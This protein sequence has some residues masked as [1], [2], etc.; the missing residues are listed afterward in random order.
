LATFVCAQEPPL[1]LSVV[2]GLPS[3]QLPDE[4][5][6]TPAWQVPLPQTLGEVQVVPFGAV[7]FEQVPLVGSQVPATWHESEAVHT[8]GF[9]PVQMP[10]W[11]VSVR[12]Q[13]LPSL[14]VLPLAAAGFEQV[15]LAGSQVPATWH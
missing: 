14:H 10:A 7:G 3:S 5:V 6:H 9:A 2:Q 4:E 8:T 13:A 11:Q 15:P 1:Q 12:V